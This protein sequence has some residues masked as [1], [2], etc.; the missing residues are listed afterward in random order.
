MWSH[1]KRAQ[2]VLYLEPGTLD[3]LHSSRIFEFLNLDSLHSR[4]PIMNEF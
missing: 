3:R 4:I 2:V 1:P